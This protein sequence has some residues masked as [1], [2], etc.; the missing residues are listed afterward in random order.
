MGCLGVAYREAFERGRTSSGPASLR[1]WGDC[2]AEQVVTLG[3]K[4]TAS[5]PT[6]SRPLSPHAG[7]EPYSMCVR[8]PEF[9]R[10]RAPHRAQE[11]IGQMGPE[12]DRSHRFVLQEKM[13]TAALFGRHTPNHFFLRFHYAPLRRGNIWRKGRL[14]LFKPGRRDIFC[15]PTPP[16]HRVIT[17]I[18]ALLDHQSDS[19]CRTD[20]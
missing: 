5:R 2:V 19:R 15:R 9:R 17:S 7:A 4:M 8:P 14:R 11:G 13:S 18:C 1:A 12:F 16:A 10:C 6:F 20:L 3:G